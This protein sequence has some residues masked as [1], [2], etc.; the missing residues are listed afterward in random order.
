MPLT[1]QDHSTVQRSPEFAQEIIKESYRCLIKEI[2]IKKQ[3]GRPKFRVSMS[4]RQKRYANAAMRHA[5]A[6]AK[7]IHGAAENFERFHAQLIIRRFDSWAVIFVAFSLKRRQ[8]LHSEEVFASPFPRELDPVEGVSK[9][10][11]LRG[12]SLVA[13]ISVS[14]FAQARSF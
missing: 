1:W 5:I 14:P 9:S 4:C 8:F 6:R 3:L 10:E 12:D 2:S 11:P 7:R 13:S